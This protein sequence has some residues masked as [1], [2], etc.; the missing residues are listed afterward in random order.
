M[1]ISG[2]L[3]TLFE[4]QTIY[5]VQDLYDLLEIVAIDANNAQAVAKHKG[6]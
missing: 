2:G 5:G 3:A 1:V 6:S 4:L